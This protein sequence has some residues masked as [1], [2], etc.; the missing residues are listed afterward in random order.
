M[1][2][3][4][5]QIYKVLCEFEASLVYIEFRDTLSYIKRPYLRKKLINRIRGRTSTQPH[6]LSQLFPLG[7]PKHSK[8]KKKSDLT[9]NE[10]ELGTKVKRTHKERNMELAAGL[11]TSDTTDSKEAGGTS[12]R[13]LLRP[14]SAAGRLHSRSAAG[15]LHSRSAKWLSLELDALDS[16]V[17]IDGRLS[18]SQATDVTSDVESEEVRGHGDP[19]K[20]WAGALTRE[21]LSSLGRTA[22][23]K[24]MSLSRL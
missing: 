12:H 18:R 6:P 8:T 13:G 20:V 16:Q 5:R 3:F 17:A 22:D 21:V 19:S 11:S 24:E 10:Q 1:P 14:H 9:P 23:V 15:R 2:A 7:K 4:K